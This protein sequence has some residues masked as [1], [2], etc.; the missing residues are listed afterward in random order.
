MVKDFSSLNL[1]KILDK[2]LVVVRDSLPVI[3]LDKASNGAHSM[4]L[5]QLH[6][7]KVTISNTGRTGIEGLMSVVH[8][9]S[10]EQLCQGQIFL[11]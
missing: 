3:H 11:I 4:H 5:A 7:D 6:L 1:L 10:S 9:L 8:T 2:P